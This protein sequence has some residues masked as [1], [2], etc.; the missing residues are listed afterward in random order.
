MTKRVPLLILLAILTFLVILPMGTLLYATVVDEPPRPGSPPGSFTWENYRAVLAG[1]NRSAL[2]NTLIIGIGSTGL[3]MFIGTGLAWIAARTNVPGKAFVQMAGVMPL[4][5]ST[6]IGALS[7]S[8]L[9]S[10]QQGYLNILLRDIGLP[11]FLN[12]YSLPGII[13]VSGLYYAPYAFMF[14]YSAFTLLN[15]ELEEAAYVHGGRFR[16][17]LGNITFKLVAP[18]LLGAATLIL[19]FSMEN[20]PI[21]QILGT[22][23]N[24][25]TLPSQIYRLMAT[26]PS[27][28]NQASATGAILLLITAVMVFLQRRVLATRQYVTVT[29]KGFK[30]NPQDLGRWRW[31]AFA[32]AMTYVFVAIV[33][34]IF[35]LVQGAFRSN[36]YTADVA[37]MFSPEN[38]ATDTM[39]EVLSSDALQTGLR[40]SIMVGAG[41]AVFGGLFYLVLGYYVH[42]AQGIGRRTLTY[43]AMW[44]A[45]IPALIIGLGFLWG[46]SDFH[47]IYGTLAI[48][49]LAY[50]ANLLPQGF[51][52]MSSSLIQVHRDLEES[53]EVCGAGRIRTAKEILLPLI[54]T[55]VVSTMLLIFILS[56]REISVAMFLFTSDTQLLS[57]SIYNAW[58]GGRL[59]PVAAMSL[60][61]VVFLLVLTFVA[62][63][64]F[65]MRDPGGR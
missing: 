32:F 65:G 11:G 18:S 12:V 47:F 1:E 64:W 41:A 14:S 55:G 27:L 63:R 35:A 7:W 40:N 57:I 39:R 28:P 17:V 15:P 53:A 3:A 20:F 34:P 33:L 31:P 62:R 52:G 56:M 46:W 44:P 43:I 5:I 54:R 42:R 10:P 49:I 59:P 36:P 50:I 6:L 61:Y 48:L 37:A 21:P 22:P 58:E 8:L 29:G 30:P 26:A 24:I 23:E 13:F 51:Q 2:Y 25:Q 38:F 16:N 60:V 4:F 9:A 19:V 45:A